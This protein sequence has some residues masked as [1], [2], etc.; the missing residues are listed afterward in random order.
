MPT[1]SGL[2]L[3]KQCPRLVPPVIDAAKCNIQLISRSLY[4]V[5]NE[6][7]EKQRTSPLNRNPELRKQSKHR[8]LNSKEVSE[9]RDRL[10]EFLPN[11][12]PEHRDRISEILERQDMVNRRRNIDIP[13]FYVGSILAVTIADKYAPG[14][15]GRFVGICIHRE[16]H[17]LRHKFILR[18]VIDKQGVEIM[19]EM[20]NPLILK[21]EVLKQE[22]R[23]DDSLLYLRDCP[24]EYSYIPQDL[25][26][27]MIHKGVQVPVNKT[28]V[29]L[30]PRPWS[31]RWDRFDLKGVEEFT[32]WRSEKARIRAL[33]SRQH[34]QVAKP[35]E[36][37]DLIKHYKENINPVEA[38]EIYG[39]VDKDSKNWKND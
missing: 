16:E 12:N 5:P 18:N 1:M 20:Y 37:V 38:E 33:E 32:D 2:Y 35:W 19:Y 28:K 17:G 31:Q 22:K 10:P 8:V 21:I 14:K 25:K 7:L 6:T 23:L 26:G 29:P 9:F 15:D 13:E 27:Q 24:L 36:K 39:E 30:G 4:T 34:P 11:P 3:F